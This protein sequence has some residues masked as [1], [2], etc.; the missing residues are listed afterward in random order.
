MLEAYENQD[1]D[2]FNE[3]FEPKLAKAVKFAFDT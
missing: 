1:M 2:F 3:I